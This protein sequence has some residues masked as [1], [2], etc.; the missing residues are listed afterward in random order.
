M[1]RRK[2]AK[3]IV[4]LIRS[5]F[6]MAAKRM[7]EDGKPLSD[8]I[9]ACLEERPLD[10]LKMISQFIPKEFLIDV[11]ITEELD[12]MTD[13]ALE[14]EIGRLVGKGKTLSVIEGKGEP[15]QH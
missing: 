3:E 15:T 5:A 9:Y 1:A 11:M 4:P 14:H 10:T 7:E 6:L 12:G 8:V 13:E 2:Q